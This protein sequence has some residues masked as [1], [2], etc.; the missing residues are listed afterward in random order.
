[1]VL[2]SVLVFAGL[3][4]AIAVNAPLQARLAPVIHTPVLGYSSTADRHP[5][6]RTDQM[7]VGQRHQG[8]W[9]GYPQVASGDALLIEGERY[10][11][12]G[13][14][15]FVGYTHCSPNGHGWPCGTQAADALELFIGD[16]LI[17][18]HDRGID[19]AGMPL[20]QCRRGVSDLGHFLVET[21]MA[22]TVQVE[23][24]SYEVAR[25]QAERAR[26][27]AWGSE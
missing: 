19:G 13:I 7:T 15:A 20:V 6:N 1:M 2:F 17:A 3:G 5:R 16:Y 18:C 22:T 24:R 23:T 10:R 11:L 27:G 9:V 14:R 25:S 12:W 21:G 4:W 26:R 8:A